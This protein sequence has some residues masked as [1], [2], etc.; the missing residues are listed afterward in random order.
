MLNV[1]IDAYAVSPIWGS[2]PGMGWNW[3]SN[4]AHFCN[5]HIITEGEWQDDIE[6]AVSKHPFKDNLHFYYINVSPKVRTMC[7]NQGS[8]MFYKYYREWEYL[9]LDQARKICQQEK[10]DV[11]HKLNMICFREP[12]FLWQIKNIPFVWGPVGGYGAFDLR[13]LKGSPI[14]FRMKMILKNIINYISFRIQPRVRK[15]MNSAS[16]VVGA[17]KECFEAIRNVYT[18]DVVLINET[19]AFI[20]KGTLPHTS[21]EDEFKVMWVGKY[22]TRKQLGIALQT[23]SLLKDKKNIHLYVIGT[24]YESDVKRY[25]RM[26]TDF[27]IE[28]TVHLMGSIPNDKTRAMMKNMDLFLFTSIADATSTVVPEAISAGLPVIC[29]NTCGF[30]VLVDERIGRKV[31]MVNPENS[32]IEFARIIR[33]LESNR[34]EV[35]RMS[36]GCIERQNE[37]S[38]EANAIKMVKLYEKAISDFKRN[39]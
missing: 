9:A 14:S 30:G 15:A 22:D 32:A 39:K 38:W 23:M 3:I 16:I 36:V 21:D 5:L 33:E 29:H 1:L 28:N 13:Y 18:K 31:E 2:E 12:G 27:Q 26:V 37:I 25:S 7:W 10:I 6:E 20:D 34:S 8:W 11:L 4:L 35:R 17:Y 24:G 19:G